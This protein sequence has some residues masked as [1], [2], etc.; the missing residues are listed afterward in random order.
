MS[1][2]ISSRNKKKTQKII[3]NLENE[4]LKNKKMKKDSQVILTFIK[5]R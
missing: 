5:K 4:E 3:Q 2:R 1:N